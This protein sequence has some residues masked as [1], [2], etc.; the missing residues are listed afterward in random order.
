M[1]DVISATL[2]LA[3]PLAVLPEHFGAHIAGL[4]LDPLET[5]LLK[6]RDLGSGRLE[7]LAWAASWNARLFVP[8]AGIY[9]PHLALELLLKVLLKFLELRELYNL[10]GPADLPCSL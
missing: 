5:L 3:A 2:A 1:G 6:F 4:V 7:G 9:A 8:G 10:E